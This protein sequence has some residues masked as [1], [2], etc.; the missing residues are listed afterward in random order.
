MQRFPEIEGVLSRFPADCQPG[1]VDCLGSAG[2]FSGAMIWRV[3]ASRGQLCLRRWP[4]ESPDEARL[5]WLQDVVAHAAARGFRLLPA[6][7]ATGSGDGYCRHDGR[8]WELTTWMPGKADYCGDPR[9]AKLMAAA[10]ALATFHRAVESFNCLGEHSAPAAINSLHVHVRPRAPSQSI[11]ERLAL[12]R[13]LRANALSEMRLALRRNY[14]LMPA[15][16]EGAEQLIELVSPHL[17]ALECELKDA[18]AIEVPQQP[19]LRDIWHDHVLFDGDRVSGIVD[20]GSMRTDNVAT[21]IARLLGSLCANDYDAWAI[22]LDAYQAVRPLAEP[23][24]KLLAAF[25]HSQ[26]LLAGVKW[27]EWVFVE[28]RLFSDPGAVAKRMEHILSRL[29]GQRA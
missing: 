24:R 29:T 27:V 12:V 14:S 9:Q 8:L 5:K 23:E 10:A 11:D 1:T 20:V 18:S 13:R 2:G 19:C 15:V 17:P 25:D 26:I 22:G 4:L 16:A 7:I 21:D 3:T 28:R 6:I